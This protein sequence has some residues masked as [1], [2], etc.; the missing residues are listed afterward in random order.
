VLTGVAL[1]EVPVV[2]GLT[3]LFA[4]LN[5]MAPAL[6]PVRVCA[7]ALFAVGIIWFFVRLRS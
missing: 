2:L 7:S 3:W 5:R 6:R 4:R 1:A